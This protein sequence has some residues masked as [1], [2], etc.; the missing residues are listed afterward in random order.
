MTYRSIGSVCGLAVCGLALAGLAACGD[1]R[2]TTKMS[3]KLDDSPV[4]GAS[5]AF[6][7]AGW[8]AGDATSWEEHMRTRAQAQ[9]EYSRVR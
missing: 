6:S 1:K 5:P 7:A 4:A 8:K 3:K 2:D 9:N